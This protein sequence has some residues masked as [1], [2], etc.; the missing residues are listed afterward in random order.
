[1]KRRI[2][3]IVAILVFAVVQIA[4]PCYAVSNSSVD[5]DAFV[6]NELRK[7]LRV[8]LPE[9][10]EIS[11]SQYI[12]IYDFETEKKTCEAAF[13]I[14]NG[15][16]RSMMLIGEINGAYYTTYYDNID[17]TI[18]N[19]YQSSAKVII[20]NIFDKMV[21]ITSTGEIHTF[22]DSESSSD[23]NFVASG[24]YN[25]V[26]ISPYR[27]IRFK[28]S[29]DL[30]PLI[31]NTKPIP[32]VHNDGNRCWV[33][34]IA[35]IANYMKGYTLTTMDVF[36]TCQ[37]AYQELP[38]GTPMWYQRALAIYG[39]NIQTISGPSNFIILNDELNMNHSVIFDV[40]RWDNSENK[41]VGH[42]IVLSGIFISSDSNTSSL[43]GT[44]MFMDPSD[45][46]GQITYV[47]LSTEAIESGAGFVYIPQYNTSKVYTSWTYTHY[48]S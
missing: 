27:T 40:H 48:V 41:W 10:Y 5:K 38:E 7:Y 19:I 29:R 9:V 45:P 33:A 8:S 13:V 6:D 30:Y 36:N 16:I 32:Y 46:T 12:D 43:V 28:M 44:Y 17:L 4:A 34:C 39:L 20:G 3:S 21:M 24:M 47:N 26:K 31:I 1:M 25:Y 11:V 2:L 35:S 22:G 37:M 18:N 23:L 15:K 42:A 14:L